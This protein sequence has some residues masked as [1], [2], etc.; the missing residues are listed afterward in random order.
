MKLMGIPRRWNKFGS[1]NEQLST[2]NATD[3][4]PLNQNSSMTSARHTSSYKIS[5]KMAKAVSIIGWVVVALSLYGLFHLGLTMLSLYLIVGGF[6]SG[7][8]LVSAGQFTRAI[9]DTADN[10]S[11]ILE[12]MK[13]KKE[14]VAKLSFYDSRG[15]PYFAMGSRR[16]LPK[17]FHVTQE[18]HRLS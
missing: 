2:T 9:I 4:T 11:Q 14:D 13:S 10:T 18:M 7:I 1:D 16:D 8:L 17:S 15:G 6:G 3:N 12:L 5:R